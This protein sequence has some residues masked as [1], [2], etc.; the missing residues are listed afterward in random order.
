MTQPRKPR[1]LS[2]EEDYRDYQDRDSRDG[3][4]YSDDSG[5]GSADPEN[6]GYGATPA[7]FDEEPDTGVIVD[8]ADASGLEEDT[9]RSAGPLPADR[10]DSDALEATITDWLDQSDEIDADSIDVHADNGIVTLEG[11]V[12][13]HSL[14]RDIEV[15]VLS[16]PGVAEVRN[17]LRT[18]GVD[19]HIPPDA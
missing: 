17:N 8:A 1:N 13:T 2:R 4:P 16:L 10:I 12:E 19:S 15:F 7:N 5:L 11:S 3:W 6:R 14:L 18:I 9:A